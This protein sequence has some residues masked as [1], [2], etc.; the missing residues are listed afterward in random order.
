MK[1][2]LP[3]DDVVTIA[4]GNGIR[5]IRDLRDNYGRGHW[6]KRLL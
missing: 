4:E 5:E 3:I 2:I 1:I 6:I